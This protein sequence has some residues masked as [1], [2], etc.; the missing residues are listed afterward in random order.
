M[1][2]KDIS[3]TSAAERSMLKKEA[4]EL[5]ASDTVP[6]IGGESAF[7]ANAAPENSAAV[8]EY[9]Q[10]RSNLPETISAEQTQQDAWG[11]TNV[12]WGGK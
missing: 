10:P 7:G 12:Y 1:L 4:E 2:T 5:P 3:P 8:P 9:V 11:Y 6:G